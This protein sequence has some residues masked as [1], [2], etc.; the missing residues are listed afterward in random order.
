M[1]PET[2]RPPEGRPLTRRP[3]LT[4]LALVLAGAALG[5]GLRLVL[6]EPGRRLEMTPVVRQT[7]EDRGSP[8]AGATSPDVTV[9]VFT[10]ALCGICKRDEPGLRRLL[11]RDGG[12][13]VVY[14]DWP[15]RGPMSELTA[16]TALAAAYQ[17][18]YRAVHEALMDARGAL[19]PERI[20]QI[21]ADA[22]A[23]RTRLAADLTAHA[24]D[25]DRQLAAHSLQ[26]FGLGLEG[27]PSWIV[28]RELYQGGLSEG[29][30]K[31]AV[32]EARRAG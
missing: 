30:L 23:D 31:R 20:A 9:V 13:R 16:R 4:I 14:K 17:G 10:D 18:R 26:A 29:A 27:T 15:I 22:G 7:L 24:R 19:T 1:A 11:A 25:I 21:A 2:G 3:R 28:G 6:G 5:A 12:V 32:R 8:W